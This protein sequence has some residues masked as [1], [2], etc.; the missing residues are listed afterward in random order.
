MIRRYLC[1]WAGQAGVYRALHVVDSLLL[2]QHDEW[3]RDAGRWLRR[4]A[5]F[6][7]FGTVKVSKKR[8][9]HHSIHE[10]RCRHGFQLDR[11]VIRTI[12]VTKDPPGARTP[13]RSGASS[14]PPSQ[15]TECFRIQIS[16][17]IL[18]IQ[19][20]RSSMPRR[21]NTITIFSTARSVVNGVPDSLALS[22]AR[23]DEKKVKKQK[24]VGRRKRKRSAM[25]RRRLFVP[26]IASR[27]TVS[28][29]RNVV[30]SRS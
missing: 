19:I 15:P 29:P 3:M 11:S 20:E 10:I 24:C 13:V 21:K 9:Q 8:R 5:P 22:L 28:V 27:R 16:Q 1:F 25:S 14:S 30:Q 7:L 18:S 4:G 2:G 26:I 6:L 17:S 23:S 12:E